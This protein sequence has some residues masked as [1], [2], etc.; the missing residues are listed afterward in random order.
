MS[1]VA[2][3]RPACD[4]IF[5]PCVAVEESTTNLITN[6]SGVDVD[7][8]TDSDGDGAA[9]G[10]HPAVH[11]TGDSSR[12]HS[13]S[14]V[15]GVDGGLAQRLEITAVGNSN[16]SYLTHFASGMVPVAASTTYT[17]SVYVRGNGNS[18]RLQILEYDSAG[19]YLTNQFSPLA[20]RDGTWQRLEYT[21]TTDANVAQVVVCVD[22]GNGVGQWVEVDKI[23]LEQKPFATS[24]VDGSRA[25]GVLDYNV[26]EFLKSKTQFTV[27]FWFKINGL[28]TI[29]G[30]R[31]VLWTAGYFVEPPTM[32]CQ[33]FSLDTQ[34]LPAKLQWY[35]ADPS[36]TLNLFSTTYIAAGEWHFAAL[37]WDRPAAT[38]GLYLDGALEA[39]G[40]LSAYEAELDFGNHPYIHLG[41]LTGGSYPANALFSNLIV[42]PTAVDADTVAEWYALQKPFFDPS[43]VLSVPA[44]SNVTLNV[45]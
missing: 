40:S 29:A 7:F 32:A 37:V 31:N 11:G 35:A 3:I 17:A 25:A 39:T 9:D 43:P 2:T 36:A 33:F 14:L 13:K 44:P 19:A 23:Q 6:V 21:W 8:E 42:L 4:G 45:A 22:I 26:Y 24:F 38:R 41:H 1:V 18:M 10:W 16:I 5:G 30:Q 28:S 15:E 34:A 20:S 27:A 12:V